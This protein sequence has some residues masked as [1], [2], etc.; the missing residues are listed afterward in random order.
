MAAFWGKTCLALACLAGTA[1]S[2]AHEPV[3]S[4]AICEDENEWPPYSYFE[5]VKGA[6]TRNVV[7]FGVDVVGEIFRKH[8]ISF[9]IDM[10]PWQRCLAVARMGKQF[11]LTMNMSYSD[12][13]ARD[14]LYSRP[15]YRT[16]NYY[17]YSRRHHPDGL[18]VASQ[19]D[20][21]K[22]RACGI[23]GYNYT[24]Y[25]F[26]PGEV[27]QGAGDF[28]ALIAKL[29]LNRCALFVE[30]REI[31][32]GYEAIGRDY[33]SDPDIGMAPIPG[34]QPAQFHFGVSRGYPQAKALLDLLNEELKHMEDNGRLKEIG[35]KHQLY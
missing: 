26:K 17:F 15:Y 4:I 19:A 18:K 25:G 7:G 22:F 9:T 30:K 35:Q 32:Y 13:R 20:L 6:R 28:T 23:R 2:Y 14:F 31:M 3:K 29:H 21:H 1:S 12:E 24:G 11:Q 34:M 8:G 27:D 10:I 33:L 16:T 5:R